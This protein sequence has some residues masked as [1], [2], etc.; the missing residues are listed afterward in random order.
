M[1][2]IH[3]IEKGNLVLVSQNGPNSVQGRVI[4]EVEI[5]S[6]KFELQKEFL[7]RVTKYVR[8]LHF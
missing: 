5:A 7:D 2:C 6:R 4:L 8:V 1:N 3:K